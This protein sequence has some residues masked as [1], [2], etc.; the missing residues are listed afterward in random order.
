MA[1]ER[2]NAKGSGALAQVGIFIP[3]G[4]RRFI[5]SRRDF[6]VVAG[7][8][9]ISHGVRGMLRELPIRADLE[10]VHRFFVESE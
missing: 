4:R 1:R 6:L 7:N 3:V 8:A 5:S 10:S 9:L 2:E